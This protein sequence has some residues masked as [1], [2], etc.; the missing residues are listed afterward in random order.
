MAETRFL[1]QPHASL[2]RGGSAVKH[3]LAGAHGEQ[4][5][6]ALRSSHTRSASAMSLFIHAKITEWMFW[7]AANATVHF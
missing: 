1:Q 7:G 4:P 6:D 2:L 3:G 5:A